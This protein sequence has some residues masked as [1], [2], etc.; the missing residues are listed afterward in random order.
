MLLLWHSSR[1]RENQ[2]CFGVQ[3]G[4]MVHFEDDT[5]VLAQWDEQIMGVCDTVNKVVDHIFS[6]QSAE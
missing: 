5:G 2:C 3:V 1:Q 4:N 6:L